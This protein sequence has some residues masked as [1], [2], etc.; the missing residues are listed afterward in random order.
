MP[1]IIYTAAALRDIDRLRNFLRPKNPAAAR[2]AAE[3][4]RNGLKILASQ[5]RLGRPAEDLPEPYREWVIEFGKDGYV[6]RYR[7]DGDIVT[8]LAARHGREAGF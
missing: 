5:P 2:R 7:V 3:A 8:I 6:V 4:I 1:Q